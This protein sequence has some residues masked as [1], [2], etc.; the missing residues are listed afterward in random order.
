ML[1]R[2]GD[3]IYWFGC[4]VA[5]VILAL[6]VFDYWFGR[7]GLVVL[8]SWAALAGIPWLIGTAIRYV[9]TGRW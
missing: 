1:A 8:G 4:I 6:G 5:A 2:L 7:D 3:V 9:L